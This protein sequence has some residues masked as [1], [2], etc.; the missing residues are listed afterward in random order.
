MKFTK[1]VDIVILEND[2]SKILPFLIPEPKKFSDN[3]KIDEI[4][5]L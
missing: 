1:M 3:V 2:L 4:T 5:K